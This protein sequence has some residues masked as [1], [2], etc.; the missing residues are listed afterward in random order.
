MEFYGNRQTTDKRTH[1]HTHKKQ[2]AKNKENRTRR[3]KRKKKKNEL[4]I[5]SRFP[6]FF[7]YLSF[8]PLHRKVYS[9]EIFIFF[10]TLYISYRLQINYLCYKRQSNQ[11]RKSAHET[12]CQTR[13]TCVCVSPIQIPN[14]HRFAN[15]ILIR[16]PQA[17]RAISTYFR[18]NRKLYFHSN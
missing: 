12:I 11:L 5:A 16:R 7:F 1:K 8:V 18:T 13:S 14:H 3:L 17:M 6:V 2:Q 4:I 15:T 9:R 10:S